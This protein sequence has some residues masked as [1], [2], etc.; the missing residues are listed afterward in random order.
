MNPAQRTDGFFV[1]MSGKVCD[2]HQPWYPRWIQRIAP[3]SDFELLDCLVRLSN[4]AKKKSIVAVCR[5]VVWVKKNRFLKVHPRL[6]ETAHKEIDQPEDPTRSGI[7][8]I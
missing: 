1:A 5:G 6:V 8:F 4:T 2:T 3:P 7:G